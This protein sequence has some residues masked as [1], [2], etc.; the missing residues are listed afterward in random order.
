MTIPLRNLDDRS[1]ADLVAEARQLIPQLI[2]EWTDHN[3]SDPGITLV[4]LFAWLTEMVLYRVNQISADNYV[5]FVQLLTGPAPT[6]SPNVAI[7]PATLDTA[8]R[9]TITALR[10]RYRAVTCEDYEYLVLRQWPQSEAARELSAQGIR[11][12]RVR[13]FAQRN[14]EQTETTDT[15]RVRSATDDCPGHISVVVIPRFTEELNQEQQRQLTEKLHTALWRFLDGR[16]LLT[17]RHHVVGPEYITIGISAILYLREDTTPLAVSREAE[18]KLRSFFHPLTGGKDGR[19]WPFGRGV[20]ASEIYALLDSIAGVDFVRGVSRR[21]P[22]EVPQPFTTIQILEHQLV[23]IEV[24]RLLRM[25]RRGESW[26]Q[27]N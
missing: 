9:E 18:R 17:T 3:P 16:R 7:T 1:Y 22:G 26:Q 15:L 8:I 20:Y 24:D 12:A 19:G 5:A 6:R 21:L 25:E 23:K 4:E 10:E 13:C 11:V 2:P 27:S 14:L